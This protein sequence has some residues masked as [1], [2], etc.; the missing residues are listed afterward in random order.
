MPDRL[1][2]NVPIGIQVPIDFGSLPILAALGSTYPLNSPQKMQR[3]EVFL[4]KP[5]PPLAISGRPKVAGQ[6]ASQAL[7]PIVDFEVGL[8]TVIAAIHVAH[9][10]T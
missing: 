8:L 6:T 3:P 4:R 7:A 5:R 2:Q 1:S 10:S 9:S